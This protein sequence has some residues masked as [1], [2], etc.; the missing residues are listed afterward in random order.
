MVR[1]LMALSLAVVFACV[2]VFE[3]V[4]ADPAGSAAT[5]RGSIVDALTGEPL[6]ARLY[7]RGESG[8]WHTVRSASPAGTAI[9]YDK[10]RSSASVEVHTSLS[11][12]PFV[13]ELPAGRYELTAE[14]GHEYVPGSAT[15][16]LPS[17][18]NSIQLKLVRWVNMAERGWYSGETHVHRSLAELPTLL[19]AEDLN[20]ALPLTYW[21]T[22]AKTAPTQGKS[23]AKTHLS[24]RP[25]YVDKTHV[26]YPLNTEYEIFSV[27]GRRH[28]LGAVFVLNHKRPLE[29]GVPPV[30][31]IAEEARRQ[32]ALL[33][34][35]KHSWPWSLMLVPVMNVDLFELANNHMWRTEFFFRRW[36]IQTVPEFMGIEMDAGGMSER[37][38]IEF[39]L[40][41]YYA[42]LNCGFRLRPTAGTA[43]GV[44]PVPLGF[45]RVYVYLPDGFSYERWIEGLAAGRSF[46][47]TGPMLDVRFNGRAPGERFEVPGDRPVRCSIEG[48]AAGLRPLTRIELIVNGNVVRSIRPQN[49]NLPHGGHQWKFRLEVQLEPSCWVALRCWEQRPGNRVRFAHTGPVYFDAPGRPIR[50]KRAEVEYLLRRVEEELERNAGVLDERSLEE[51]REAARVYR[52]LLEVAR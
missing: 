45:G 41:T 3:S 48:T 32:G 37:G 14:R 8:K 4:A 18:S 21:V 11:A 47:T 29:R 27:G 50:P 9:V 5:L 49:T 43:S 52:R 42:L 38:W 39:G 40:K 31:P 19:L 10:R 1:F 12:H 16:E 17:G 23:A 13:I 30:R 28:I 35:D 22:T 51:Y 46:V 24:A 25:I 15:V 2:A 6:P 26:I 7:I 34:L 20:V 44:H 33:D 36:M